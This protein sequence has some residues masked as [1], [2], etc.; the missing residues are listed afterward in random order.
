MTNSIKVLFF[1]EGLRESSGEYRINLLAKSCF[2]YNKIVKF[3]SSLSYHFDF[4]DNSG[5]EIKILFDET[6]IDYIF[7]HHSFDLPSSIPSNCFDVLRNSLKGKLITFSGDTFSS[8]KLGKLRRD[9]VY[10]HFKEFLDIHAILHEWHLNL[11]TERNYK[12]RIAELNFES[13]RNVLEDDITSSLKTKELIK[14]SSL[15]G[16]DTDK[17]INY[18]SQLDELSIIEFL[19]TKINTI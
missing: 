1:D 19:E 3:Y 7:I 4:L 5:N 18:L 14:I 17:L 11:F 10:N 8:M 6:K 12:R 13:F 15:I 16:I 9:D 2:E